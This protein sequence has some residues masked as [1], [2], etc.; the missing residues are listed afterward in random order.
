M[1]S[2][3]NGGMKHKDPVSATGVSVKRI[4]YF[5]KPYQW[6]IYG[7]MLLI[8]IGAGAGMAMPFLLRAV[9]D[10]A[11]PHAQTDLLI[12]LV[13]AMISVALVSAVINMFQTIL[14]TKI[15]QS[16][17]HD[18]RV[19]VYAHLQLLPLGFFTDTR[20]G[21][22]QSRITQ[23][24]GSLQELVSN[25]AH[26]LAK[27]F[28][29]VLMTV[30]AMF[31]L[32]WKLSLF[33]LTVVPIALLLSD[34][35]GRLR[36][37]VADKQRQRLAD[38]SS[39]INETLS[40]P[41][42]I[43]SRTMGKSP[44]LLNRFSKTSKDVA[45]LEVRSLTASEWQWQVIYLLLTIL[46]ALTLL[47]GGL[48][49]NAGNQVSIGTLVALIALQEQLTWPLQELLRTGIEIRKTRILFTR[50][51]DYLDK[52]VELTENADA[53]VLKKENVKGEMKIDDVSFSYEDGRKVLSHVTL[54]VPAGSQ[55][56]IVGATG[57]GKTTLGY[58]MARLYDP[59][60]GTI[61]IDRTDIRDL[62]FQSLTDI[63]GV[64]SQD[65]YLLNGTIRENLLFAHQDATD[66][67]MIRV[68]KMAK[69]H[70]FISM[71]PLAYETS[72]GEN[73]YRFSGGEK[74]RLSLARTLLR[75]PAIIILDEATSALD[76]LTER[77]LS[78]A[79]SSSAFNKT[80]I[81]IAHRLSTIRHA[82]LIVVMDEGKILEKGTHEDLLAQKNLYFRMWN[83]GE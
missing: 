40:V 19:Q 26:E 57:S 35:V 71:L 27:N 5:F 33:S 68:S 17:L 56:A 58:L 31:V 59:D 1:N 50:I 47:L 69:L 72:I 15:G 21:E 29:V 51:F 49:T 24:I 25:S 52:P 74:Q 66:Q 44:Y 80:T 34:L 2:L 14:S 61:S 18:F 79:L 65:P 9:I 83:S 3:S 54:D 23:D 20:G 67:D 45:D 46:P 42:I 75:N 76:T 32:D 37:R 82:D 81:I 62:S 48:R 43:L 73:G 64:V 38:M 41:G 13:I 22:I 77:D 11:L 4:L 78:D 39:E 28:S 6:Q 70:D 55:V 10:D 7:S 30:I 53:L 12:I 16:V 63:L 8:L 60:S 36:E